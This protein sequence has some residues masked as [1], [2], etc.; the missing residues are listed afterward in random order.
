[1]DNYDYP[2]LVNFTPVNVATPVPQRLAL[3]VSAYA[4]ARSY[5]KLHGITTRQGKQQAV[6]DIQ[7]KFEEYAV[8]PAVIR[9][10][11]LVF[12][13]KPADI[14]V[15]DGDMFL[16]D[17][18]H[19]HLRIFAGPED[20]KGADL[21]TRHQ[22]YGKIVGDCL[23]EMYGDAAVAP[24]DL[25]HVTSTG[26]L[27]PSPLERLVVEKKWFSTCVSHCY[28][29][30]S[31]GA[32]SAIKMAHGFLA[33]GQNGTASPRQRVDIVH[34]ELLSGHHDIEDVSAANIAAM[35]LYADGFINYSLCTPAHARDYASPGLRVLAFNERLLPDSADAMTLVPGPYRFRTTT[36]D[37]VEVVIRR[38][39]YAFVDDLLGRIGIDFEQA[40]PG[41]IFA[42][43]PGGPTII[44]RIEDELGLLD[45]QVA[46]GQAVLRENGNMSSATIPH[47]LKGILDEPGIAPGTRVVCLGYGPGLTLAG[48]VL[49]K[50]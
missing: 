48:L 11:Q 1:M 22:Y 49:E 26:Y 36:S 8:P 14:R 4:M 46:V 47:V 29:A 34:T 23:G 37:M 25:I 28:H 31:H 32:F 3:E 18:E 9:Q 39:V 45:D 35:S 40:R 7:G 44:E 2:V 41:L 13:P 30:D 10:R 27:A 6:A 50:I 43:H 21:K 5:C 20:T 16:A 19:A 24:D 42:I 38:H 12:F 33:S 15:M 17:P